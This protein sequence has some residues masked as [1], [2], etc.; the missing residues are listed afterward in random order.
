MLYHVNS[1]LVAVRIQPR[2]DQLTILTIPSG[3]TICLGDNA[4]DAGLVR[5]IVDGELVAVFER[6]LKIH[7]TKVSVSSP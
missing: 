7:A 5:T 1:P 6:D 3:V 2:P 4:D